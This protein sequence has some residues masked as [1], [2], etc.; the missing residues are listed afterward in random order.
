MHKHT[1]Q[2]RNKKKTHHQ[3][4]WEKWKKIKTVSCL[5]ECNNGYI[6]ARLANSICIVWRRPTRMYIYLSFIKQYNLWPLHKK[7]I[8]SICRNKLLDG[9]CAVFM[10]DAQMQFNDS[11]QGETGMN[12]NHSRYVLWA[13]NIQFASSVAKSCLFVLSRFWSTKTNAWN[14]IYLPDFTVK[15]MWPA[16]GRDFVAWKCWTGQLNCICSWFFVLVCFRHALSPEKYAAIKCHFT[17][18]GILIWD[19]GNLSQ[20]SHDIHY[21]ALFFL[22]V[23]NA[24]RLFLMFQVRWRVFVAL[25]CVETAGESNG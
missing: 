19:L 9:D 16:G 4:D 6:C 25:S 12:A 1:P 20:S 21:K 14:M 2:Q 22:F 3:R 15:S 23:G 10:H 5:I 13:H 18:V 24:R 8:L 17:M 11:I 7:V